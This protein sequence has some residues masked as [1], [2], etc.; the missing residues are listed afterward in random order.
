[1][2]DSGGQQMP[3]LLRRIEDD[4]S[5]D[6]EVIAGVRRHFAVSWLKANGHPDFQ[7]IGV[8]HELTDEAAFFMAD[9]ENRRRQDVSD[10]ERAWSYAMALR[11]HYDKNQSRMAERLRISKGW[12]SKMLTVA[13]VPSNILEAFENVEKV[14][15]AGLYP[16]ARLLSQPDAAC[17]ITAEATRIANENGNRAWGKI[18]PIPEAEVIRLLK[19]AAQ[20]ALSSPSAPAPAPAQ[21]PSSS[22]APTRPAGFEIQS[23]E[24]HTMITVIDVDP[25]GITVRLHSHPSVQHDDLLEAVAK[26]MERL[27]R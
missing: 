11:N 4:S 24:G 23:P 17:A 1:M 27:G 2:I 14:S 15:L 20:S 19:S 8:V 10:M 16:V 26:A 13:E 7:F 21:A 22:L 9:M 18:A 12:L 6:F 25:Q 5:F 3:A